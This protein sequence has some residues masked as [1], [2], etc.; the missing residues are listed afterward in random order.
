MLRR[1][2]RS[3]LP[4]G[5]APSPCCGAS[6]EGLQDA[7]LLVD[8]VHDNGN[9]THDYVVAALVEA[10]ERWS[11]S[12]Y[13]DRQARLDVYQAERRLAAARGEPW[14]ERI[15]LPAW[16][17]GAPLP[18]VISNGTRADLICFAADPAPWD[19]TSARSVSAADVDS[20]PLLQFTFHFCASIK[21]GGP[22]DEG[23]VGHPLAGR[24]L[25][26][27]EAHIVHDSPWLAEEDRI[28]AAHPNSHPGK[29]SHDRS[30]Y[31]LAFHDEVFEALA[32]RLEI[33]TGEGTMSGWLHDAVSAIF[34]L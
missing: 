4:G 31:L 19:G 21:F 7:G 16:A 9:V 27:Y 23:L 8:R 12:G 25:V 33:R 11:S 22:N 24:G 18:H 5:S 26:P 34:T 15:E 1:T 6:D 10:Q 30:H 32:E 20:R 29:L 13:R 28:D 17:G 3:R 2:L 14:A